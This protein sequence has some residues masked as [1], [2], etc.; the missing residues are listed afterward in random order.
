VTTAR[1][2]IGFLAHDSLLYDDL[3]VAENLDFAARLAGCGAE[4]VEAALVQSGLGARRDTL[5]RHLSRGQAQRA[6]LMRSLLHLPAVLLLDEPYTGLDTPNST[7]LTELL[8]TRRDA[9]CGVVLVG[10]RPD[11]GWDVVTRVAM[12]GG[13]RWAFDIPRPASPAEVQTKFREVLDG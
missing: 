3:T 8:R 10:H 7:R 13:G 11:E 9:G 5:V 6:A 4:S 2:Q 1:Q 12:L